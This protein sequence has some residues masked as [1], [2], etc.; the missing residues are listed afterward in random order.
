MNVKPV[1]TTHSNNQIKILR[2]FTKIS[3]YGAIL[4][5]A[6]SIGAAAQKKIKTHKFLGITSIILA[7]TH[8]GI[9]KYIHHKFK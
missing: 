8:V 4:T 6:V 1:D 9:I 2:D 5:G 3:G 7:L